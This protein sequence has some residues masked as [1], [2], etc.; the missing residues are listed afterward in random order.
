MKKLILLLL[1]IPL[2]SLGQKIEQA[3]LD[4]NSILWTSLEDNIKYF[5]RNNII[6][7]KKVS[8]NGT[9]KVLN[10]SK[11]GRDYFINYFL[12]SAGQDGYFYKIEKTILFYPFSE[13]VYNDFFN[14]LKTKTYSQFKNK[15]ES[16]KSEFYI[17]K[18]A[19]NYDEISSSVNTFVNKNG[20]DDK[21]Y[22][23]FGLGV[24]R[25]KDGEI[26][27]TI[28]T[29]ISSADMED[30]ISSAVRMTKSS[31][32]SENK[33]RFTIGGVDLR[34][35]NQYDLEAMVKFF[36]EDCKKNNI[37]VPDINSLQ[38]TFEPLEGTTLALAYGFENDS[39]IKI[40]VDPEKWA[41]SSIQKRWYVI[42]HELGHDVLNLEH[43][44]GGKMMFNFAD[45]EYTW[46]EFFEDK[47]YM[48]KFKE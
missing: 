47:Q 34:D 42:Y 13:V 33:L 32:E 45:R 20:S 31:V 22:V 14:Q 15:I 5:Q 24:F 6:F 23:K 41:E 7:N 25:A 44:Q 11:Q 9:V 48:I 36:L 3:L 8:D 16:K 46:D 37:T 17:E 26:L 2:V 10:Y 12:H 19:A 40:K 35:I 27:R 43:G 18:F 29:S 1:F 39:I 30:M 38:A 28:Y 21:R 4:D